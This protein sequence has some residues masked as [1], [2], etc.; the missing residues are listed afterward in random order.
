MRA[1]MT[2]SAIGV[3]AMSAPALAETK[4][5]VG[6]LMEFPVTMVGLKPMVTATVDGHEARFTIDSGAF[7]STISPGT[8]AELGLHLSSAPAGFH[9][10]GIGGEATNTHVGTV[11]TLSVAG[12]DFH[13]VQ[14]LVAGSEVGGAGLLGQNFLGLADV[15]Y[16]LAGGVVRLMRSHD[17]DR[18]NLAYWVAVG[19]PVSEL[20]IEPLLD[21]RNHTK[22]TVTLDGTKIDATFDT[23]AGQTLLST[24]AAA[25]AGVRPNSPGVTPAGYSRGLGRKFVQTWIGTFNELTI[26]DEKIQKI[27]LRFGDMSDGGFDMLIGADFF[28]SHRVYVDNHRHRLFF[29]YNGGPVFDLK[30][31]LPAAESGTDAP[32]AAQPVASASATPAAVPTGAPMTAEAF[33]RRGAAETSRRDFA[34][35]LADL[36]RATTLAPDDADYRYRRAVILTES[37]KLPAARA[38]VDRALTLRPGHVDALMLRA[39]LRFMARDRDGA[40]ADLDA[41]SAAVA[42]P[43]DVRLALANRYSS[44]GAEAAAIEQLDQWIAAHPDDSRLPGALNSRCWA[45]TMANVAIDDAIADCNRSLRLRPHIAATFDSRGLA[46]LRRGDLD[47]AAKDFEAALAIDP[48]MAWSLYGRGIVRSRGG[49]KVGSDSD[50]AAAVAIRPGI[51]SQAEHYGIRP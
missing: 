26:G 2:V 1:L 23:G 19:K 38:D 49:D 21:A 6:Q 9:L 13:N 14:F 48:K 39:T 50:I 18:A 25:R 17:C 4:C 16:D 8:A 33:A 27:R 43:A 41:I 47:H 12:H 24:T 30:T 35:A 40:R 45:R 51:A 11:K 28:L 3:L 20:S 46:Y 10:R 34:A 5:T 36:D 32:P 31:R 42:K 37:G 22:G 29:T 15:E 7:Y 44:L